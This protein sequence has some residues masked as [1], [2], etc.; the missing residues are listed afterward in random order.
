MSF[1][2]RSVAQAKFIEVLE[3][4]AGGWKFGHLLN[5]LVRVE[6]RPLAQNG[7]PTLRLLQIPVSFLDLPLDTQSTSAL[8]QTL[9]LLTRRRYAKPLDF[10]EQENLTVCVI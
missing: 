8:C 7:T 1:P 3:H 10:S 5:A 9:T 4:L 2:P 6:H